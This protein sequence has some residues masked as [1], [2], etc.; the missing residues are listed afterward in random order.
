MPIT[1]DYGQAEL[2]APITLSLTFEHKDPE[3]LAKIGGNV[4]GLARAQARKSAQRML[5]DGMTEDEKEAIARQ[6]SP[7][8]R[9]APRDWKKPEAPSK[10]D[11]QEAVEQAAIEAEATPKVTEE[12]PSDIDPSTLP[13]DA[14]VPSPA[15]TAG[16]TLYTRSVTLGLRDRT[17]ANI[18]NW[19][20]DRTRC[21]DVPRSA[22]DS[23]EMAALNE[24]FKK[25][26]IDRERVKEGRDAVAKEKADLARARGEANQLKEEAV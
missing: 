15:S 20:F 6:Q 7:N 5:M 21:T 18:W 17:A 25:S 19:F 23:T 16:T 22:E 24:F 1:V 14:V 11:A 26:A 9:E 13:S 2:S 10:V 12:L 3:V 4:A 8:F